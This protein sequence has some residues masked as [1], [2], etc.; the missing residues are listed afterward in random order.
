LSKPKGYIVITPLGFSQEN[1][2]F[3]VYCQDWIFIKRVSINKSIFNKNVHFESCFFFD[4]ISL[5][6]TCFHQLEFKNTYIKELSCDHLTFGSTVGLGVSI[7]YLKYIQFFKCKFRGNFF[8][9]FD[10]WVP[11]HNLYVNI[12][13][14]SSQRPLLSF[15]YSEFYKNFYLELPTKQNWP[16]KLEFPSTCK[17][18]PAINLTKTTINEEFN[19]PYQIMKENDF[20]CF[21]FKKS[22]SILF[23]KYPPGSSQY[24]GI[25]KNKWK[26]DAVKSSNDNFKT[27]EDYYRDKD[28]ERSLDMKYYYLKYSNILLWYTDKK[29][30][31]VQGIKRKFRFLCSWLFLDL[32]F[33]YFTSWGKSLITTAS[34]ILVF[35]LI[36]LVNSDKI[37]QMSVDQTPPLAADI[38]INFNHQLDFDLICDVAY[39]TLVTFTT[40]GYGDLA[41]TGGFRIIAGIEGFIGI[42]L[43]SIFTVTLAK[44]VLG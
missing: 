42:I 7:N 17:R 14:K 24:D 16:P 40:I 44:R 4:E 3:P 1:V 23:K 26:Y 18:N 35:F 32:P 31:S 8:F 13:D 43:T 29:M 11:I 33:K 6:N 10:V 28:N 19:I 34:A 22:D 9:S 36:N 15:L 38:Y 5:S 41:P 27:L 30:L 20:K 12:T 2:D 21:T 25:D 39:F 37:I